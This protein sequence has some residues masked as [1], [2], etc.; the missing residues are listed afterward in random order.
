MQFY[1]LNLRYTHAAYASTF[2]DF[3]QGTG[4]LNTTE[5]DFY[6]CRIGGTS[7]SSKAAT[8]LCKLADLCYDISFQRCVFE[9]AQV[10][11]LGSNVS[12]INS[13]A[14]RLVQCLFL[15]TFSDCHIKMGG[16]GWAIHQCTFEP[17]STT[18]AASIKVNAGSEVRGLAIHQSLFGDA[19]SG[20]WI[21]LSGNT[22]SGVS[23]MGN[24]IQGSGTT[25]GIKLG[26]AR[27]VSILGNM[28]ELG[29]T[30]VDVGTATAALVLG[31]RKTNLMLAN[32]STLGGQSLVDD[33]SRL[34]LTSA[35]LDFD[36]AGT[37]QTTAYLRARNHSDGHALEWGHS[38]SAGFGAMLGHEGGTGKP[39]VAFNAWNGTTVNTYKT[40]GKVGRIL[41]ADLAGG[42]V[43][44]RAATASADNQSLTTDLTITANGET[45]CN[46]ALV[47]KLVTLTYGATITPNL[48][49]GNV[50]VITITDANPFTIANP[51]AGGTDGQT[52]RFVLVNAS[53]GAH[54]TLSWGS[55]YKRVGSTSL[56]VANGSN[57]T[58]EFTDAGGGS[59]V[60]YES[61]RSSGDVPN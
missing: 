5:I 42:L 39:Y 49:Q 9:N 46:N 4:S 30:A 3:D 28:F 48:R 47:T 60:F 57:Q 25:D 40:S 34:Y 14:I 53:G 17:P 55:Q 16:Q 29:G 20:L 6:D 59:S 35:G 58:I 50:F 43:I 8:A 52:F 7:T 44:G 22:V 19:T 33:S 2:L 54:G 23:I 27:G 45:V 41:Q 61:F 24:D 15:T 51:S 31:N 18:V 26:A 12:H 56:T 1:G 37:G 10:A 38:N 13:N 21:D 36:R 32:L 11:A